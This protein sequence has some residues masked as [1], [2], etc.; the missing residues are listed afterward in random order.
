MI[1]CPVT[2]VVGA[3][4]SCHYGLPM[5]SE[6]RER[7]I[8]LEPSDP[9]WQLLRAAGNTN[10]IEELTTFLRDLNSHPTPSID[11]FLESCQ[12]HEPSMRIGRQVIAAL[13]AEAVQGVSDDALCPPQTDWLGYV[14]ERMRRGAPTPEEFAKGNAGVRFV[15]FN[16]DTFIERRLE[17]D[18]RRLYHRHDAAAVQKAV[19]SICRIVHVHGVLPSP[20]QRVTDGPTPAMLQWI[21]GAAADIRVVHD[22]IDGAEVDA[23]RQALADAAVWCFLGF[24]YDESNLKRLGIGSLLKR[25]AHDAPG[26]HTIFGSAFRL[27]ENDTMWTRRR[28]SNR[29]EFGTPEQNCLSVVESFE[30]FRD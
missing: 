25:R 24:A 1:R 19:D 6:L 26:E 23:A 12:A 15:T 22:T 4:A 27:T 28:F 21:G 29:I 7:A 8:A 18:I 10:A 20:P 16:F 13:M 14:I 17:R 11:A 5:G 30:L 3:G 2:F 9:I